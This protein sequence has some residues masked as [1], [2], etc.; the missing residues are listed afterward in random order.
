MTNGW[1]LLTETETQA[2]SSKDIW[3]SSSRS[4][5]TTWLLHLQ[6]RVLV[7]LWVTSSKAIQ[8]KVPKHWIYTA[9]GGGKFPR[10]RH[11]KVQHKFWLHEAMRGLIPLHT[12]SFVSLLVGQFPCVDSGAGDAGSCK[13]TLTDQKSLSTLL[14]AFK[15][16]ST[17]G[18]CCISFLGWSDY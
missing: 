5:K 4:N 6:M 17:M 16:P 1:W 15:S 3:I 2:I 7:S 10:E 12:S 14:S 8:A 9:P 13:E 18:S 11:I